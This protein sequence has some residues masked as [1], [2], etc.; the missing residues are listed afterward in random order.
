MGLVLVICSQEWNSF[1][2]TFCPIQPIQVQRGSSTPQTELGWRSS[3][4]AELW[5][6]ESQ[7]AIG[8]GFWQLA[9][10]QELRATR[11][12]SGQRPLLS[13]YSDLQLCW[14]ATGMHPLAMLVFPHAFLATCNTTYTRITP[15]WHA[16]PMSV[17]HTG[18]WVSLQLHCCSAPMQHSNQMCSPRPTGELHAWWACKACCMAMTTRHAEAELQVTWISEMGKKNPVSLHLKELVFSDVTV[19]KLQWKPY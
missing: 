9:A 12:R 2:I 13:C 4:T 1:P 17:L 15:S 3:S 6:Q 5:H 14:S 8:E 7:G 18:Q 11:W 16:Q 10:C 19:I